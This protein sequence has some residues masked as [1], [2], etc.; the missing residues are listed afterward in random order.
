MASF[1]CM[2]FIPVLHQSKYISTIKR[3]FYYCHVFILVS[4]HVLVCMLKS[5]GLHVGLKILYNTPS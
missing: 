5:S 3:I 4:Y 2:P 1:M